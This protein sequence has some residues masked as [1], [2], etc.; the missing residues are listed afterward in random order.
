MKKRGFTL[1]ELLV[2]IVII[3]I[4]IGLLI[5]GIQAARNAARDN[6]SK[7]N[8]RQITLAFNN[9]YAAKQYFPPSWQSPD[10]SELASNTA[11]LAGWSTLALLLPYL[12]QK[13]TATAIDYDKPCNVAVPVTLADG[14]LS[15]VSAMRVPT[16]VSPGEPRDE[17]RLGG[18]NN[19]G[20]QHYPCNYGVN[21]GTWF[22][23][24]PVTG[25]GG[26]GAAYPNSKLRDGD[27][28]DG[29]SYT[30][31]FS[32]V[33]AWQPFYRNGNLTTLTDLAFPT[34]NDICSLPNDGTLRDNG[35]TEWVD[36][37]SQSTG[38]TTVFTPNERVLCTGTLN[39]V[40]G[41]Y[42][43]DWTNRQEGV[44]LGPGNSSTT[45]DLPTYAAITA[46]GYFPGHVNVS[47]VDGSVRAISDDINGGV[48]RALST[49]AGQEMLP[50]D[51]TK[52]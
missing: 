41:T 42:D 29:L 19:P 30:L 10:V 16:Y 4:L 24:D 21:L 49:R 22:V 17:A 45:D 47:M 2:V 28:N 39:S 1:V 52:Q 40:A 23:W 43:I 32:E 7:N 35:H 20:P 36:G 33:K 50:D 38:F 51:I 44:G 9:H 48:W 14:R 25:R 27:F 15:Q 46:R 13:A 34:L 37:R 18:N 31:A 6:S 26:Y 8:L 3:G 12:E 5:P 11:D